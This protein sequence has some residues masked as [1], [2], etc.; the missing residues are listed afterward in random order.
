MD[1]LYPFAIVKPNYK[2]REIRIVVKE[3]CKNIAQSFLVEVIEQ[4]IYIYRHRHRRR[5]RRRKPSA[6]TSTG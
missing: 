2:V 4:R 5:N 6:A 3:E 1:V